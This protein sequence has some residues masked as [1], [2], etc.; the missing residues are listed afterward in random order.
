MNILLLGESWFVHLVHQKGFDS[1]TTS[2]YAE[3]GQ[4]FKAALRENGWEVNHIP[5]HLIA[6]DM[7][8][9]VESL[10]AYDCVVISDVGANTFLLTP[11]VFKTST[12]E[13]N[14]LIAVRDYVTAG[15]ALL[16]IGG[17][18]SFSGIDGKAQFGRS[19]LAPLLPVECL[20]GDDRVEV[21]QGI[22]PLVRRDHP[23][24]PPGRDWPSILGYNE[25]RP[26]L[27]GNGEVLVEVNGHP[28]VAVG[29]AGAGRVGIFTSDLSPHWAPRPFLDWD[30]YGPLW[31]G[32]ISWL[33]A[34]D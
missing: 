11:A 24:L 16:M 32:L 20:T 3:G 33:T 34:R 29:S 13:P 5:A 12:T 15:G 6:T 25:T 19:P 23:A 1:F 27:D 21:P 7:P 2:E 14:R 9:T 18:L 10:S 26:R 4:E 22:T 28:L 31:V 17:Y 8:P 30:G